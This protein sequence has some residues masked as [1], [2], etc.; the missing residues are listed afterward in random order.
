MGQTARPD[1]TIES[2]A[3]DLVTAVIAAA[4]PEQPTAPPAEATAGETRKGQRRL[5][6]GAVRM[7][8]ERLTIPPHGAA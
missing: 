5:H 3:R 4:V 7:L 8:P 6:G 2:H 1:G